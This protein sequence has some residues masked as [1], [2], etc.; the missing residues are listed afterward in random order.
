MGLASIR[1]TAGSE[2]H[3]AQALNT[4]YLLSLPVDR[5]LWSF[6]RVARLPTP[7]TPFG[8]WEDKEGGFKTIEIHPENGDEKDLMGNLRM[9]LKEVLRHVHAKE[10]TFDYLAVGGD[11]KFWIIPNNQ[12]A[13]EK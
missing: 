12:K 11:D 2:F 7:G 4:E 8:A 3:A 10:L 13:V 6:R 9:A 1:L 5:L